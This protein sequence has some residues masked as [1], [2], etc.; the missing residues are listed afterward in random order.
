MAVF[1]VLTVGF[2]LA[3]FVK[4]HAPAHRLA[5]SHKAKAAGL[6]PAKA[7]AG[8]Q[9]AHGTAVEVFLKKPEGAAALQSE[10]RKQG[11]QVTIRETQSK[12]KIPSG[13]IV[14]QD[15]EPV[16]AKPVADT[17]SQVYHFQVSLSTESKERIRVQVGPV[18]P[19]KAA[20][21]KT[22]DKLKQ[23]G[24]VWE[25]LPGYEGTVEQAQVVVENVPGDRINRLT[26]ELQR[27]KMQ[28]NITQPQ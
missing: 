20:A 17:L 9:P 8:K 14:A 18:Y 23:L 24:F 1:G 22:Q 15:L 10:L 12:T 13:F 21:E 7:L 16:A 11:Y 25:I 6:K 27:D 3:G 2:F 19:S 4:S 28:Y 5:K 26:K